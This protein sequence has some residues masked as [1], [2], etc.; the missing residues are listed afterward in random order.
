MIQSLYTKI[1]KKEWVKE[2]YKLNDDQ[3]KQTTFEEST[4]LLVESKEGY[5]FLIKVDNEKNTAEILSAR[6]RDRRGKRG[7]DNI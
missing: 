1:R 6:K 4:H 3:Q 7:N 2:I 5:E